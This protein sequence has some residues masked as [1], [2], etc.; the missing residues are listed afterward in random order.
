MFQI[1]R[2][3]ALLS[4][5]WASKMFLVEI[6]N[7]GKISKVIKNSSSKSHGKNVGILL[8]SPVN[9]HSHSLQ[10]AIANGFDRK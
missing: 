8:P 4:D 10:R 1:L 7:E 3:K 5:G 6:T 2:K 9:V